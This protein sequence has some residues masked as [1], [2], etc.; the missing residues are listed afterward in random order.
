MSEGHPEFL[1]ILK[2][3][4]N[5]HKKKGSDYGVPDDIF[6][7]IRQSMDWGVQPW[8]GSMVRAGDKVVRLKAA[9]NGSDLKNEGV[10]DS[11]MDLASYAIIALVLYREGK[12]KNA[13]N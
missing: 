8:V 4:E 7:N 3:I 13:I 11:L 1:K 12:S 5:M 6:L 9:A 10:E 2:D